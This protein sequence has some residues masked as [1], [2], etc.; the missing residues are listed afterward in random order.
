[1]KILRYETLILRYSFNWNSYF[2]WCSVNWRVHCV[3][4]RFVAVSWDRLETIETQYTKHLKYRYVYQYSFFI[5]WLCVCILCDNGAGYSVCMRILL[6]S[7]PPKI[8]EKRVLKTSFP[9]YLYGLSCSNIKTK[10]PIL[11]TLSFQNLVFRFFSEYVQN[12]GQYSVH[13]GRGPA[14]TYAEWMDSCHLCK[15]MLKKGVVSCQQAAGMTG[16]NF[17]TVALCVKGG[18]NGGIYVI[19]THMYT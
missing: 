17:G 15:S 16:R 11:F 14:W 18:T 6:Y 4:L 9:F 13:V 7:E 1:M 3:L 2:K 12:G 19:Y 10:F 5:I 8:I